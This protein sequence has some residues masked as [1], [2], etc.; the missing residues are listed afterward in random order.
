MKILLSPAKKIDIS[1]KLQCEK[2]TIPPFLN[3][4]DILIQHLKKLSP[5]DISELM[6]ISKDLADL[7]HQ[8]YQEW[9]K[10]GKLGENFTHA[11]AAFDGE[12]YRGLDAPSMGIEE[13]E[14]AQKKLIILSGLYGVL[15]PLDLIPPYRLEMGTKLHISQEI[16]NLYQFWGTK[17]ANYINQ[18][19]EDNILINLASNEY[20][21]AVDKK[22]L[23]SKVI[24]PVFKEFKNGKYK[25]VMVY[26]K[27][28]RGM[29]ARYIIEKNISDI[30]EIKLFDVAGYSFDI[31][32]SSEN[33][34]VFVR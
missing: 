10:E 27:K 33:E 34:W 17:I 16:K 2:A 9:K 28:A 30:Q 23:K 19:N 22:T 5:E 14:R 31:H 11:A 25:V 12:V 32:Q 24:T 4:V 21:K 26:A 15:R 18:T 8:R 6:K 7:N 3:E 20:F 1:K 13:C 29:M